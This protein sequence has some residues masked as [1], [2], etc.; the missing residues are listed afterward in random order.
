M[1]CRS[2]VRAPP[3]GQQRG[4]RPPATLLL[5]AIPLLITPR[6]L[7]DTYGSNVNISS[8]VNVS[9]NEENFSF[10]RRTCAKFVSNVWFVAPFHIDPFARARVCVVLSLTRVRDAYNKLVSLKSKYCAIIQF[11]QRVKVVLLNLT[12][13]YSPVSYFFSFSAHSQP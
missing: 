9:R 4:N 7:S 2:G 6:S 11:F 10:P 12:K 1:L 8:P 3:A 5:V 13:T